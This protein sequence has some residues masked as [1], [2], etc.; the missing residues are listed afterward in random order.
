MSPAGGV[1][2]RRGG[3]EDVATVH[4]LVSG[5]FGEVGPVEPPLSAL[6]ETVDTLAARLED[7]EFLLIAEADGAVVGCAFCAP[8]DDAV[9]LGR[10]AVDAS[11]RGRGVCRALV[12]EAEALAR[13]FARVRLTLKVRASM[14]QNIDV[15][16]RLGFAITAEARHEGYDRTTYY[17]LEKPLG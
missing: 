14:P 4:A 2:V 1:S 16:R 15:F 7:E 10:V 13:E 8:Q 12:G 3:L 11:A 9:Y 6:R 5:A 17:V